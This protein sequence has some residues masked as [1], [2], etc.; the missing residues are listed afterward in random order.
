M[1]ELDQKENQQESPHI[2]V[3]GTPLPLEWSQP[4]PQHHPRPVR[5]AAKTLL[6][7][8][9]TKPSQK[10]KDFYQILVRAYTQEPMGMLSEE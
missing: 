3:P 9:V 7:K 10:K 8:K 6:G 1:L 4:D 5:P 2:Q